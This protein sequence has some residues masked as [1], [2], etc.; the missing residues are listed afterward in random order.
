M[1]MRSKLHK[2]LLH[3]VV[4]ALLIAGAIGA[5]AYASDQSDSQNE[6]TF[7]T[8]PSRSVA[9]SVDAGLA[10]AFSV[11]RGERG[12]DDALPDPENTSVGQHGSAYGANTSLARQSRTDGGLSYYVVPGND[13]VCIEAVG[14]DPLS[15]V[16][17]GCARAAQALDGFMVRLVLTRGGIRI[18]GL[19]PDTASD[20]S[21]V[22]ADG[23][24]VAAPLVNNV[25]TAEVAESVS[26]VEFTLAGEKRN[27]ATPF[28]MAPLGQEQDGKVVRI[29]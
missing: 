1:G 23:K 17:G 3:I 27:L 21:V 9:S 20:V 16:G 7:P 13:S 24:R 8:P 10:A 22:L 11:L 6:Q 28:E 18:M 12:S 19:L 14:P 25:Y 2:R 29:R 5:V 15:G 4:A 26:S